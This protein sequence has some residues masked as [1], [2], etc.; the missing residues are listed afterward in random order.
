[1]PVGIHRVETLVLE[2]VGGHFVGEPD[3]APLLLE[4]DHHAP[5]LPYHVQGHSQ[6]LFAIAALAPKDFGREALVMHAGQHVL[7]P[8]QRPM[9]QG[10][11][12]QGRVIAVASV[13]PHPEISSVGRHLALGHKT[14]LSHARG[15]R[16]DVLLERGLEAGGYQSRRNQRHGRPARG[17]GGKVAVAVTVAEADAVAVAVAARL[18]TIG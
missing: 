11:R 15:T 3:P 17:A 12:L 13:G 18:L 5:F 16:G 1:M 8:S 14:G 7:R 4:V 9:R 2:G 6:L 10:Y